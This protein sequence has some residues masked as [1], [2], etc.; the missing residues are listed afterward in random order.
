VKFYGKKQHHS[1]SKGFEKEG[2]KTQKRKHCSQLKLLQRPLLR[3]ELGSVTR[4][5]I[6]VQ[7]FL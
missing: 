1:L 7:D 3:G 5:E 2:T 6:K 4:V